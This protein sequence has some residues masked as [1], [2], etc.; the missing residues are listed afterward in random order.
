MGMGQ[1][2]TAG[3]QDLR[4]LRECLHFDVVGGDTFAD[5]PLDGI[6]FHLEPCSRPFSAS[7]MHNVV[8]P[9]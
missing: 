3:G 6:L 7:H 8:K 1:K 4:H 5:Y 2:K 9:W